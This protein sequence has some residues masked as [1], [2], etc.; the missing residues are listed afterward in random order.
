MT[1]RSRLA[2]RGFVQV[3]NRLARL[4]IEPACA[5]FTVTFNAGSSVTFLV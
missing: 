2:F 3:E 5:D 4:D 1:R